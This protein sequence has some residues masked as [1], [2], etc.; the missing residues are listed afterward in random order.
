MRPVSHPKSY[1]TVSPEHTLFQHSTYHSTEGR[2][3]R[4]KVGSTV[5][6]DVAPYRGQIEFRHGCDFVGNL[7]FDDELRVTQPACPVSMKNTKNVVLE[8][9]DELQTAE[10]YAYTYIA[11]P[12][13][14][15][16][17]D[18]LLHGGRHGIA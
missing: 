2:Y 3:D 1:R 7:L 16:N 14:H 12:E 15:E 17:A 18:P 11:A 9:C 13:Y 4:E 8:A 5:G 6:L 10:D